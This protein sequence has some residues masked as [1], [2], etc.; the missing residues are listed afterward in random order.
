LPQEL[1]EE[2]SQ[3]TLMLNREAIAALVEPNA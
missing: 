1:L 3:A 2:L